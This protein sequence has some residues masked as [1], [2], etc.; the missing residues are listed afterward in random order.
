MTRAQV[1]SRND[2]TQNNYKQQSLDQEKRGKLGLHLLLIGV[3]RA[4]GNSMP[5]TP[6]A[7]VVV[8]VAG[9]F[10]RCLALEHLA[11]LRD[12]I[13]VTLRY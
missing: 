5:V 10:R 11:V 12:A 9:V 3:L 2:L 8:I 4:H 6:D 7:S 13:A 1:V